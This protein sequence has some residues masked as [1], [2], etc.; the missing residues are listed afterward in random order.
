MPA[1]CGLPS[2]YQYQPAETPQN[3]GKPVVAPKVMQNKNAPTSP[4]EGDGQAPKTTNTD[5]TN[6]TKDDGQE[7]PSSW[8]NPAWLQLLYGQYRTAQ[9]RYDKQGKTYWTPLLKTAQSATYTMDQKD[10]IFTAATGKKIT[11]TV[12]FTATNS[13]DVA[14]FGF[15]KKGTI[16]E[17]SSNENYNFSDRSIT[18]NNAEG[19]L[20]YCNFAANMG[21]GDDTVVTSFHVGWGNKF[22]LVGGTGLDTLHLDR[23]HLEITLKKIP[24]AAGQPQTQFKDKNENV[25]TV[26][27]FERVIIGSKTY[28]MAEF[29]K[30][31]G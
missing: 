19:P 6:P 10:S 7:L 2:Q 1:A 25:Y 18:C 24:P 20:D 3:N 22:N 26:S 27:E 9:R 21:S 17:E 16:E 28:T 4:T 5:P 11:A 23:E 29:W 8:S 31:I 15:G 30:A 13:N 14:A 12:N